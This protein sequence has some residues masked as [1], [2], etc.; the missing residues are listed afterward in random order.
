MKLTACVERSLNN[1]ARAVKKVNA[2]L[3]R[4]LIGSWSILLGG[5]GAREERHDDGKLRKFHFER[6][7]RFVVDGSA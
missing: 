1:G 5:Q 7:R 4:R 3:D 6:L 2:N